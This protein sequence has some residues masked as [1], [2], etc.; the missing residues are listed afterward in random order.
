MKI[1]LQFN[2]T[3]GETYCG[4]C[5]PPLSTV[6]L[7]SGLPIEGKLWWAGVSF[8]NPAH[9]HGAPFAL[10][11]CADDLKSM[12]RHIAAEWAKVYKQADLTGIKTAAKFS[13]VIGPYPPNNNDK[14]VINYHPECENDVYAALHKAAFGSK[15]QP[16]AIHNHGIIDS[17]IGRTGDNKN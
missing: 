17:S 15:P 1:S 13:V 11:V 2:I 8:D 6:D 9:T 4:K 7:F 10:D 5:V 14:E 3:Y 12:S 16:P